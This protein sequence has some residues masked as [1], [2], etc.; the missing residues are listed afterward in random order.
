MQGAAIIFFAYIGFDQ[1]ATTAQEARNPQRDVPWGIEDQVLHSTPGLVVRHRLTHHTGESVKSAAPHPQLTVQG[2][3]G[4]GRSEPNRGCDG[5]AAAKAQDLAI[6]HG[7]HTVEFF[8]HQKTMGRPRRRPN[9]G[10]LHLLDGGCGSVRRSGLC[11]HSGQ[12]PRPK[13]AGHQG[14]TAVNP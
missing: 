5:A 7:S 6:P 2:L 14:L 1:A 4:Q 10:E 8:T 13:D 9:K 12:P 3:P 11:P